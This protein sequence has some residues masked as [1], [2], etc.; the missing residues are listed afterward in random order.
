MDLDSALSIV[1]QGQYDEWNVIN[2][3]Y[4][5]VAAYKPDL[6]LTISW[7]RA[8]SDH[9]AEP[10]AT[11]FADSHATSSYLEVYFASALVFRT[12]Y[13]TVD[14]GRA[15]LPVPSERDGIL[16]V[17]REDDAL[18]RAISTLQGPQRLE[19]YDEY[20]RRAGIRVMDN[21]HSH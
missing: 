4:P 10:W 15:D 16:T 7:G 11:K 12:F 6:N 5:I 1:R 21:Q 19:M 14:G 20:F 2:D 18:I 3:A 8:R 17:S 9:F 13:V